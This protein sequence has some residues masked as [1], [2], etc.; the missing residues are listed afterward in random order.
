MNDL[1]ESPKGRQWINNAMIGLCLPDVSRGLLRSHLRLLLMQGAR[2]TF[3]ISVGSFDVLLA[4][5]A[6][7]LE[8]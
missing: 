1:L 4:L 8:V 2:V 7:T 5:D 6:L 3:N